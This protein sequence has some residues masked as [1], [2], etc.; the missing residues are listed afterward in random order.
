LNERRGTET[1]TKK[2]DYEIDQGQT[3]IGKQ[4]LHYCRI[5]L[6]NSEVAFGVGPAEKDAREKAKGDIRDRIAKLRK[7]LDTLS[8]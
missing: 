4:R 7:I 6:Q 1:E 3:G 2:A 8:H 5:R